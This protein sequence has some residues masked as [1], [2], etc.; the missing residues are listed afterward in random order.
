MYELNFPL[1]L[2]LLPLPFLIRWLVPAHHETSISIRLPFFRQVTDAVGIEPSQGSIVRRRTIPHFLVDFLCWCLVVVALARPQFVEPPLTKTEPQRDILLALDLSQSMDTRDF[3]DSD[4]HLEPRV[5]AVKSVVTD[6]VAKRPTDR[7]GIVAFGDAPYPLAPFT[8]DHELVQTIIQGLLPGIAGPR[9]ALGDTLGLAIRMFEKTDVP[10]KVLILLTDGNDTA[11]KM[12]PLKAAEI[13]KRKKIVVHTIGIGNPDAAGEDKLD[14]DTL[15]KIAR[16][17]GGNYYFGG[18]QAQLQKIYE[19]LDRI[20]PQEQKQLTWRP[21]NELF[22]WP[23]GAAVILLAGWY[24]A[25]GTVGFL[26]RR[27]AHDV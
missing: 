14:T 6:F 17:T 9:T 23:L 10:D 19:E 12:P 7:L 27:Y 3:A 8:M 4:A 11:S 13:A 25:V 20:T 5:N 26:R 21:R 2:L 15:Q 22:V 24:F 18:D 1:A 16:T